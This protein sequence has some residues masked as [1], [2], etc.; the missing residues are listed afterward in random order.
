M[1]NE[2]YWEKFV[3]SVGLI[4]TRGENGDDIMAAAWTYQISY[5]PG[6]IAVCIGPNKMTAENIDKNKEFGLHLAS[7]EQN[8]LSSIAGGNSGKKIDKIKVLE[9][10][11]YNFFK[12]KKIKAL[13][14]KNT[15]LAVECKLK[16][17]IVLGDHI[18]YVGEVIFVHDE[19]DGNEPLAY[20]TG[21]YFGLNETIKKPDDA[22][23]KEINTLIKK[24]HKE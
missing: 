8:I 22:K 12:A 19:G 4:T 6:L 14:I 2:N 9:S 17:K 13:M 10:L 16:D 11:G 18:M 23:L 3:T 7:T 20:R 21:K 24:Y 5:E 15:A 1:N